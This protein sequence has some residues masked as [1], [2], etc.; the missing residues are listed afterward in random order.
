MAVSSDQMEAVLSAFA[1]QPSVGEVM[2]V[3]TCNRVE[4]VAAPPPGSTVDLER[5]AEEL[6]AALESFATPGSGPA[7]RP[8]LYRKVGKDAV[9][10][11]F[12]VASSLDSLVVG[13][14][15]ILGQVKQ[16][17][18]AAQAAGT[19]GPGLQRV[20]GRAL[21]AA[22]RVRSETNI[23]E[24]QVSIAS[25]AV[26][27][28]RQI[29]GELKGHRALLVGAGQM[30]ES[31]AQL[32]VRSGA[33][34]DVIN[35]STERAAALARELG[36]GVRDW[37]ELP[38]AIVD[39]DVVIS[40]TSAPGFV[41]THEIV[42]RAVKLRKGRTLFFI[43]IA[44]PRD[45]EPSVEALNNVFL[46]DVDDLEG[47]VRETF[48]EREGAAKRAE[49]L[50]LEEMSSFDA[51]VETQSVVPTVVALRAKA[52][53]TLMAEL[54]RSLTGKLKHLGPAERAA[55]EVMVDAG[56]NKLL[57][58]PIAR[59]KRS[60]SDPRGEQMAQIVRELFELPDVTVVSDAP[61]VGGISGANGAAGGRP[62]GGQ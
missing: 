15:Q 19:I 44:V 27:L 33:R 48:R 26:D 16:A 2:C 14:P 47:V 32:V 51:W 25:V 12:R 6:V 9:Q 24:G 29:F 23:G 50:V 38:S 21:Q 11:L 34:L 31:A 5:V 42:S 3:S 45:I 59:L 62:R 22:K 49:Q 28:A 13:E 39:T 41:L 56:V 18:E 54:E 8:H 10:H 1:G 57:H 40:S 46:Y 20:V 4:V 37:A 43:D 61:S 53:A 52:R 58:A 60:V 36:A 35:R 7:L 30:A 55:L 17:F